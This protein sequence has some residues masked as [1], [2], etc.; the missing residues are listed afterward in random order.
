VLRGRKS[1]VI[2]LRENKEPLT[3]AARSDVTLTK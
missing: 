1:M 3:P 2:L